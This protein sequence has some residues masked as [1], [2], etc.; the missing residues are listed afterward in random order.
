MTFNKPEN[1]HNKLSFVFHGVLA[2]PLAWFVYLFLEIKHRQLKPLIHDELVIR[3]ITIVVPVIAAVVLY[4][5]YR[6]YK[7]QLAPISKL[8]S[9]H[10]KLVA[11]YKLNLRLYIV[12][13]IVSLLLVLS[14]YLTTAAVFTLGYVFLL[15]FMSLNRPDQRKYVRDLRLSKQEAEVILKKG[16]FSDVEEVMQ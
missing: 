4:L 13:G 16:E 6:Y 7:S 5:A 8:H 12:T 3:I 10:D 9:L 1:F 11:Y 14:L 15:F 2:A